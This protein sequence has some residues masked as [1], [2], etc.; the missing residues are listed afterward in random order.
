MKT[1]NLKHFI[2]HP[3]FCNFL[4]NFKWQQNLGGGG[5]GRLNLN[6]TQ[7]HI[8]CDDLMFILAEVDVHKVFNIR[9]SFFGVLILKFWVTL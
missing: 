4:E 3:I 2:F 6:I 1:F 9:I 8:T 5:E 7:L